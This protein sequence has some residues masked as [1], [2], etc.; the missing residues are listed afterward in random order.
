MLKLR[1]S[2]IAP[3]LLQ[4]IVKTSPISIMR[5][6]RTPNHIFYHRIAPKQSRAMSIFFYLPQLLLLRS[7]F[8][9]KGKLKDIYFPYEISN[10]IIQFYQFSRR[11]LTLLALTALM[12][13]DITRYQTN[14]TQSLKSMNP[15]HKIPEFNTSETLIFSLYLSKFANSLF[16]HP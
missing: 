12:S 3:T 7:F 16:T 11:I 1:F 6:I 13:T 9:L 5:L 10:D 14:G 15:V 8:H 2:L 4:C